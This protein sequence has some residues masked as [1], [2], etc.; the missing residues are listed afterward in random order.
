MNPSFT[1]FVYILYTEFVTSIYIFFVVAAIR[2]HTLPLLTISQL[3]IHIIYNALKSII[4]LTYV[5]QFLTELSREDPLATD[6]KYLM[7][8]LDHEDHL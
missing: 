1:V 5:W 4:N 6:L 7:T 3:L 2:G 8:Y